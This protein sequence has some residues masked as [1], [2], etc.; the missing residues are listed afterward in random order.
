MCECTVFNRLAAGERV[1][2]EIL[3]SQVGTDFAVAANFQIIWQVDTLTDKGDARVQPRWFEPVRR[4][5]IAVTNL[6]ILTDYDL[7][8]QDCPINNA[9][10]ADNGVKE[11]NG[12]SHNRIL[13]DDDT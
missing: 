12:V 7:F 4:Y 6:A 10:S 9:A 8:I 3:R 2:R 11:E 13:L 5:I 1:R